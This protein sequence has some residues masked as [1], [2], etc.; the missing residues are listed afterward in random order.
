LHFRLLDVWCFFCDLNPC[1]IRGSSE[2][3][4]LRQSWLPSMFSVLLDFDAFFSLGRILLLMLLC[5][6]RTS[7]GSWPAVIRSELVDQG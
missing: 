2:Y 5:P 4:V 6:V 7:G 1:S 3:I